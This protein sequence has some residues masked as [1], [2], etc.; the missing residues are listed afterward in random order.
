MKNKKLER[1]EQTGKWRFK[2]SERKM[3]DRDNEDSKTLQ[4]EERKMK[5]GEWKINNRELRKREKT[6][7]ELRIEKEKM[8]CKE[9]RKQN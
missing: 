1:R 3:A 4:N 2:N 9:F 8:Q 7:R 6:H 5:N